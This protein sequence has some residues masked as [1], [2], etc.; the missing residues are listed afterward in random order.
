M[1][2]S[3]ILGISRTHPPV[4]KDT[5]APR[6]CRGRFP[7]PDLAMLRPQAPRS[8]RQGDA[9][10]LLCMW[11]P[12]PRHPHSC[13]CTHVFFLS[14]SVSLSKRQFFRI[15]DADDSLKDRPCLPSVSLQENLFHSVTHEYLARPQEHPTMPRSCQALPAQTH[16]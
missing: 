12:S 11:G 6:G 3:S 16:L 2:A 14:V 10:L 13:K 9:S 1:Y 15:E 8:P 7:E 4:N 5:R